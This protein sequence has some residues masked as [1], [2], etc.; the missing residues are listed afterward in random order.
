MPHSDYCG[1]RANQQ[2]L[3]TESLNRFNIDKN[4][5]WNRSKKSK[6]PEEVVNGRSTEHSF[7]SSPS[8]PWGFFFVLWG[9]IPQSLFSS[10]SSLHPS[11][12]PSGSSRRTN[13]A[14]KQQ[15]RTQAGSSH[16]LEPKMSTL[17][18]QL[19]C[20]HSCP[21]TGIS[22]QTVRY[23][24]LA[25]NMQHIL[26]AE[27]VVNPFSAEQQSQQTNEGIIEHIANFL[28]DC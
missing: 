14:C 23:S 20:F 2:W 7:P 16:S 21:V 11:P 12:R 27:E 26:E 17:S 18:R 9:W 24:L 19:H 28:H 22:F 4:W 8:H 25:Q 1:K 3:E 5:C 6:Q 13:T 10:A 15:K